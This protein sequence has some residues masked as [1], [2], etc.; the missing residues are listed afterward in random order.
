MKQMFEQMGELVFMACA[1]VGAAYL[2]FAEWQRR[3]RLAFS[4]ILLGPAVGWGLLRVSWFPNDA[5]PLMTLLVA[6]T[7]PATLLYLHGKTLKDALEDILAAAKRG[8][9]GGDDTGA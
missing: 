5:V 1:A 6:V 8:K 9:T 3:P 2:V 4:G 7:A